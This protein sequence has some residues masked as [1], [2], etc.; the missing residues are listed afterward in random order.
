M[1]PFWQYQLYSL[2]IPGGQ[3]RRRKRAA[4]KYER[5]EMN[6]P[7]EYGSTH[8]LDYYKCIFLHIP[9]AAGLSISQTLFGNFGPCHLRYDWFVKHF[10]AETTKAYYKFTFVRNPWDRLHS[11]Y[12]FLKKGGI[13]E[14]NVEFAKRRLSH[15]SSFEQFVHEWLNEE[16]IDEYWHFVPQYK[17]ITVAENPDRIMADFTGRFETLDDDFKRLIKLLGFKHVNLVHINSN[18]EKQ[19]R[20]ITEYSKEMIVKVGNLYQQDINLLGYDFK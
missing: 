4:D 6:A 1:T 8:C 10:G 18:S 9:K 16:T 5:L 20:Y 14:D 2:L 19:K 3:K 13:N 15:I 11:A 7:G 17:F 12:H